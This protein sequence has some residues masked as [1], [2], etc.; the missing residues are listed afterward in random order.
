M[1]VNHFVQ[2]Q[3]GVDGNFYEKI[4]YQEDTTAQVQLTGMTSADSNTFKLAPGATLTVPVGQPGGVQ[5]PR[6]FF[7]KATD[8]ANISINGGTAIPMTPGDV[9]L[10]CKAFME[11]A[12]TSL[13]VTNPSTTNTI[14]GSWAI[15]GDG[16]TVT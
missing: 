2:L 1:Q 13:T 11:C 9:N 10:P 14:T 6:G 12:F 8:D 3:I 16:P 15:W 7:V 4:Y 5:N